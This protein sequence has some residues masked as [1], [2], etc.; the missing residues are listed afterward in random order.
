MPIVSGALA[1][2]PVDSSLRECFARINDIFFLFL[3]FTVIDTNAV[4]AIVPCDSHADAS[5]LPIA[6]PGRRNQWL[7]LGEYS[8]RSYL[9]RK[10]VSSPFTSESAQIK[11][12]RSR[13]AMHIRSAKSRFLFACLHE[14]LFDIYFCLFFIAPCASLRQVRMMTCSRASPR[15]SHLT[16]DCTHVRPSPL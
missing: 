14:C 1:K 9:A 7:P 16:V 6:R 2:Y 10:L 11:H 13:S 15:V 8:G 12:F 3:M 5:F 4:V